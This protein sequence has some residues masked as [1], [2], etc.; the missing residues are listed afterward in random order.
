MLVG[1]LIT[2]VYFGINPA[3]YGPGGMT[4]GVIS[5]SYHTRGA[6][7]CLDLV[8]DDDAVGTHLK[9]LDCDPSAPSAAQRWSFNNGRLIHHGASGKKLCV[10][11]PKNDRSTGIRLQVWTCAVVGVPQQTFKYADDLVMTQDGKS[12]LK[13]GED[14]KMVQL[15]NCTSVDS[16]QT[17]TMTELSTSTFL[18][19]LRRPFQNATKVPAEY[20]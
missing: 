12:C 20:A 17:W 9:V 1:A 15:S 8:D 19:Q 7:R 13:V 5:L 10:D 18:S 2:A 4:T 14:G 11:I 16:S 3:D 6:L